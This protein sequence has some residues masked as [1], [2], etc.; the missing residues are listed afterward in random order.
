MAMAHVFS[1][2][3][4]N[5][6]KKRHSYKHYRIMRDNL[7]HLQSIPVILIW[8]Q[9]WVDVNSNT[10]IDLLPLHRS[11]SRFLWTTGLQH[12]TQHNMNPLHPTQPSDEPSMDNVF[13][14][15]FDHNTCLHPNHQNL[16]WLT[17]TLHQKNL[18]RLAQTL[19]FAS[20]FGR[21]GC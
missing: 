12:T 16:L 18:W 6:M 5:Y 2:N 21:R 15:Y 20:K 17:N 14:Q 1:N 9:V 4:K 8:S 11:H 13:R 19:R 7:C 3:D 10:A